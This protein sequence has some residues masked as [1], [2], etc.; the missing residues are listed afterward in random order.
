M[1]ATATKKKEGLITGS[2]RFKI[3]QITKDGSATSV[4]ITPGTGYTYVIGGD[5]YTVSSGTYTIQF[6][7]GSD[8][9][10]LDVMFIGS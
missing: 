6:S 4:D 10:K 2:A 9:D 1:A 7:A 3:Y 8:G 5:G